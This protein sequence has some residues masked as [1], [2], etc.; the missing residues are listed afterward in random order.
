MQVYKTGEMIGSTPR[1]PHLRAA[2]RACRSGR[3]AVAVVYP[4][5]RDTYGIGGDNGALRRRSRRSGRA[6]RRC[7]RRASR[8][9]RRG[10]Q[11]L[12]I[13][14]VLGVVFTVVEDTKL[15]K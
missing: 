8:R 5:L 10:L 9:C 12:L 7:S 6:S 2:A 11:A 3:R 1:L 14:V 15:K 4:L 13:A